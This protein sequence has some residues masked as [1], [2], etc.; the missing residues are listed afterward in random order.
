MA[1]HVQQ[2]DVLPDGP[3]WGFWDETQSNLHCGYETREAAEAAMQDYVNHL[4]TGEDM[5]EVAT[6]Y[7]CSW[8]E[9]TQRY[10]K[11]V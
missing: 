11:H 6:A 7:V 5:T 4:E 9:H 8:N 3:S 10:V 2:F 1:D